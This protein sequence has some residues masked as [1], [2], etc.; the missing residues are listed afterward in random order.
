MIADKSNTM[1]K[2][3][4]A[5][6]TLVVLLVA[7]TLHTTDAFLGNPS[8]QNAQA[9]SSLLS[10]TPRESL[11]LPRCPRWPR[12]VPFDPA[13]LPQTI[14]AAIASVNQSIASYLQENNLTGAF[15]VTATADQANIWEQGFGQVSTSQPGVSPS[16]TSVFRIGS[17]TKLFTV[18]LM[19]HMRDEGIIRSLDDAVNAYQPEFR[20]SNPF[21]SSTPF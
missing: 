19:L 1:N 2:G 8:H 12:P 3:C 15:H 16:S 6:R 11:Y 14:E 9:F 17:L 7:L 10:S 4:V 21:P 5:S 18:A 20:P 13:A